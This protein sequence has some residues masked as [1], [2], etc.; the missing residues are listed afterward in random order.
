MRNIKYIAVHC[1]ATPQTTSIDSIKNY[2]KTNL[3][4]KMPGYHFIQNFS[5]LFVLC[6][7]LT[8]CRTQRQVVQNQKTEVEKVTENKVSYKDTVFY[9]QKAETALRLPISEFSKCPD[10]D[11]KTNL[12]PSSIPKIWTQKNG[13]AT[14]TVKILHDSVIVIAKCDSLALAAK[15][16][17]E[18]FNQYLKD[19][20]LNDTYVEKVTQ[21]N[22]ISLFAWIIVAFVAGFITKSLIKIS[23]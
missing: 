5:F 8:A 10:T 1:T 2:W 7:F 22:W 12:K 15:I 6:L 9:T 14:A 16:K 21:Y 17:R 3:G 11:F 13:N 4:W 19:V 20:K 18:Y 23:I